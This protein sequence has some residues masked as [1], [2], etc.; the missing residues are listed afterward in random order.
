MKRNTRTAHGVGALSA[1]VK[2]LVAV[3]MIVGSS[4]QGARSGDA[5]ARTIYERRNREHRP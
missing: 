5:Q 4:L 1:V 2:R 3:L